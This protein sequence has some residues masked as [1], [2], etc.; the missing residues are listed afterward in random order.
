MPCVLGGVVWDKAN[1]PGFMLLL[2]TRRFRLCTSYATRHVIHL[3]RHRMSLSSSAFLDFVPVRRE[4]VAKREERS[5][6]DQMTLSTTSFE[7][8]PSPYLW[9]LLVKQESTVCVEP[10]PIVPPTMLARRRVPSEKNRYIISQ[11]RSQD[12]VNMVMIA[13]INR[14]CR[15]IAPLL[16]RTNTTMFAVVTKGG[17]DVQRC[18]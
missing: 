15:I 17:E 6:R 16:V 13:S 4:F 7:Q 11:C 10:H 2:S 1:I 5:N 3:V 14:Y 12:S 8:E 18:T 9:A